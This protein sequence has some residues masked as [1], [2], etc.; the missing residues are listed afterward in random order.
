M[1]QTNSEAVTAIKL[2]IN[3]TS[4]THTIS[5]LTWPFLYIHLKMERQTRENAEIINLL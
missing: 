5:K 2:N 1:M 4:N 3:Q